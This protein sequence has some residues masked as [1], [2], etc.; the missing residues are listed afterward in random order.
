MSLSC[1]GLHR[2]DDDYFSSDLPTPSLKFARSAVRLLLFLSGSD[3]YYPPQLAD[4]TAKQ[5][6][7]TKWKNSGHGKISELSTVLEGADHAVG[8]GDAQKVMFEVISKFLA[9]V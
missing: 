2:G 7:L 9:T 3:E 5:A 1:F 4:V 6:L 8:N